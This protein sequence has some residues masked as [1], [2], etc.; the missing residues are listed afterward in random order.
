MSLTR[1]VVA[2][3]NAVEEQIDNLPQSIVSFGQNFEID[4]VLPFHRHRRAQLVYASLGIMMVK[5]R[6]SSYVVPPQRAV[7]MPGGVEHSIEARSRVKMRTLYIDTSVGVDLPNEV[8]VLQ[9]TPLLRELIVEAVAAGIDYEPDGPTSRIMSVIL[10]QIRAQPIV[11]SLALPIPSDPR[12]LHIVEA[13]IAN[14][15][16]SRELEAW[17]KMV[18]ASQ[19]TLVRLFP[20]QTGMT[21]REWRQQRRLLHAV[22]LLATGESVTSIALELGYENTSAFSAMF[23]R[24]LGTTPSRYLS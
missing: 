21:F 19:R 8:C 24:R 2:V 6:S 10:D 23:R 5:T 13:L 4:D 17:A 22:E 1:Q 9:I 14:P 15:A 11:S 18:G 7:W 20:K 3:D 12:L 16:D